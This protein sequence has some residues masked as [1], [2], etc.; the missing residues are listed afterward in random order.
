MTRDHSALPGA[1]RCTWAGWLN[2]VRIGFR[3][4]IVY[5]SAITAAAA[6][7]AAAASAAARTTTTT[8]TTISTTKITPV[9]ENPC[10]GDV[11]CAKRLDSERLEFIFGARSGNGHQASTAFSTKLIKVCA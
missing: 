10:P 5:E 9:S 2:P 6:A 7:A 11:G 1:P 8:S 3:I 4:Y